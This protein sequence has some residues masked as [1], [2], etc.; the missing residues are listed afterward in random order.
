MGV[1]QRKMRGWYLLDDQIKSKIGVQHFSVFGRD[2]CS[3]SNATVC[4][5][6]FSRL[7]LI[8]PSSQSIGSGF[9]RSS[10]LNIFKSDWEGAGYSMLNVRWWYEIGY[11]E[12]ETRTQPGHPRSWQVET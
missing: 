1:R 12:Q 11:T 5:A 9:P 3:L 4:I 10:H 8:R 6:H 2:R 7:Q